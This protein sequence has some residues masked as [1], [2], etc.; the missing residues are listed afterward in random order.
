MH[1]KIHPRS[2]HTDNTCQPR[3]SFESHSYVAAL[4]VF[5]LGSKFQQSGHIKAESRVV[6]KVVQAP[7]NM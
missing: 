5:L 1:R 2:C 7:Y 6:Q 4:K 3:T